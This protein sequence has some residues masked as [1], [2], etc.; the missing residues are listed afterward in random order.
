MHDLQ[1][2]HSNALS[3]IATWGAFHLVVCSDSQLCGPIA[4]FTRE[5]FRRCIFLENATCEKKLLVL[6]S[7]IAFGRIRNSQ[8][9]CKSGCGDCLQTLQSRNTIN[10]LSVGIPDE[11]VR[12]LQDKVL[13]RTDTETQFILVSLFR[14]ETG[15]IIRPSDEYGPMQLQHSRHRQSG[16]HLATLERTGFSFCEMMHL[17]LRDHEDW[18]AILP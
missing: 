5:N 11:S 17:S 8:V 16:I 18:E 13:T 6:D 14:E 4:S 10:I 2:Q 9:C 7:L 3:A 1:I 12:Q 15:G